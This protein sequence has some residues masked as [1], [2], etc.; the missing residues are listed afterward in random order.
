MHD[1][2]AG[3]LPGCRI[4]RR[5][6]RGNRGNRGN[7]VRRRIVFYTD[8]SPTRLPRYRVFP[9]NHAVTPVTLL[10]LL[11]DVPVTPAGYGRLP[12]LPLKALGQGTFSTI[13]W[14]RWSASEK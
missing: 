12:R 1:P 14:N 5:H 6:E 9:G 3:V 11:R 8:G 7:R 2:V 13:T 10:N 4:A